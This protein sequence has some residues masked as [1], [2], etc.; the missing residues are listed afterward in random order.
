[1]SMK[2]KIESIAGAVALFAIL[3]G[4]LWI[5]HGAGW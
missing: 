4:L 5:A 2:E 3:G 1:M